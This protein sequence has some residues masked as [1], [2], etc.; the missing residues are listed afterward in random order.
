[1]ETAANPLEVRR[2][3]TVL[4]VE[5][6]ASPQGRRHLVLRDADLAPLEISRRVDAAILPDVNGGMTEPARQKHGNC[7]VGRV[8][9]R[10]PEKVGAHRD[11]G[12]VEFTMTI[13]AEEEL[14]RRKVEEIHLA[15]GNF[16]LSVADCLHAVVM[17]AG[18]RYREF[19]HD[20]PGAF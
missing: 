4:A 7:E 1:M 10:D 15:A 8:A 5:K 12:Y 14:F 17:L 2:P 6:R 13:C 20:N 18:N 19:R 3:Y 9:A 16:N 11:L